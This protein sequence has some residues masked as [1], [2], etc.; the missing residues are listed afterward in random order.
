MRMSGLEGRVE[1]LEEQGRAAS[2]ELE[3][4]TRLTKQVHEAMFGRG[5]DEEDDGGLAGK[6]RQVHGAMFGHGIDKEDIGVAGKVKE[7]HGAFTDFKRGL[8]FLNRVADAGSRW[9]RPAFWVI[10]IFVALGTY[11]KTGEWRWPTW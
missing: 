9:G 1:A 7:V 2:R 6:V 5:D 10:A 4:N 11:F 3:A 8:Q